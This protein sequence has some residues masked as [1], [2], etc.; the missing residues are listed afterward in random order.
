MAA[1]TACGLAFYP[2]IHLAFVEPP[3]AYP[4]V[5]L[6]T[7]ELPVGFSA[8]AAVDASGSS[9]SSALLASTRAA[10]MGPRPELQHHEQEQ[11]QP[12]QLMLQPL[13]QQQ[14]AAMWVQGF[15]AAAGAAPTGLQGAAP[16]APGNNTASAPPAAGS[17]SSLAAAGPMGS[18]QQPQPAESGV[19][20]A[21]GATAVDVGVNTGAGVAAGSNDVFVE[22]EEAAAAAA[23]AGIQGYEAEHTSS[24]E[25]EGSSDA[26]LSSPRHG[27]AAAPDGG[28]ERVESQGGSKQGGS[29]KKKQKK[30]KKGKKGRR[31]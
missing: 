12:Q 11:C 30:A 1:A 5:H 26:E 7:V 2:A 24:S 15:T 6:T 22:G 3:A 31:S 20:P 8:P 21:V 10:P 13:A 19:F 4:N 14:A 17:A 27:A 29:K 25:E 28:G 23:A 16:E 18:S 9:F